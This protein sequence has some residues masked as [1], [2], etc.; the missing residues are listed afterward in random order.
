MKRWQILA[1]WVSV[2]ALWIVSSGCCTMHGACGS[3]GT[4]ACDHHPILA[5]SSC[6]AGCGDHYVDEWVSEPPCVDDCGPSCGPACGPCGSC[7]PVR[8]LLR[9]LWGTRYMACDGCGSGFASPSCHSSGGCASCGGGTMH[10]GGCANCGAG[11][12]IHSGSSIP[13]DSTGVA[14]P[15][16]VPTPAP[17]IPSTSAKRL[18]PAQQRQFIGYKRQMP[19]R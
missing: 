12:T 13:S 10:G 19:P 8:N 6:M 1:G 7:Q 17:N 15:E 18:N 9:A 2:V 11:E 5:R 3:C 16:S 14:A 4:G